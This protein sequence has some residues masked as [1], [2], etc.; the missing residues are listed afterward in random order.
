MPVVQGTL[1]VTILIVVVSSVLF[2]ALLFVMRPAARR[3]V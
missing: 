2:N 3:E 1:L